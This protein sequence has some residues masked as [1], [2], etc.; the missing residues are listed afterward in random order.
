MRYSFL[1]L[2]IFFAVSSFFNSCR[3][4]DYTKQIRTLDSLRV[5]VESA[6]LKLSAITPENNA[7][8]GDSIE[9]HLQYIQIHYIG[10]M[11]MEMAE[12]LSGYGG[13][14][15]LL[16]SLKQRTEVVEKE[17]EK[18]LKQLKSL[19]EALS[20]KATH[21]ATGKELTTEYVMQLLSSEQ[22]SAENLISEI[23]HVSEENASIRDQFNSLYPKVRSCYDSIK[24]ERMGEIIKSEEIKK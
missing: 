18:T 3:P 23:A 10:S 12:V 17:K 6:G 2:T 19:R 24:N 8:I 5:Q 16:P 1:C 9:K 4:P 22:A 7:A 13:I 21:D 14:R 20:E 15:N 11:T